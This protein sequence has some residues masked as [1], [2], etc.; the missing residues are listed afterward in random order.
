[1]RHRLGFWWPY[2]V[3]IAVPAG[4]F[5]LPDLFG[6]HLLMTGDDVQQNYPLRELVGYALRH[7]QLPLWNPYLWSGTPLLG[8]F[9]AGA[10]H[11]L[12]LLFG[13]MPARAAWITTEVV[14]YA[15]V[16][17]GAYSF[18]RAL[19]LS[20]VPSFIGAAAFS[21]SGVMLNQIVHIDMV[22]GLATLPW[23]LLAV[24]RLIDEGRWR[25]SVL[26]GVGLGS[27]ILAGAPE[28]MLDEAILVGLY[29]VLSAGIDRE[30]WRRVISRGGTG[31]VFG[32]ALGAIQWLPGLTV[33]SA[34]QR[35]GLGSG[36]TAL[37]SFPPVDGFLGLVP[38]LFGGYGY[39]GESSFFSATLN[40]PE[41]TFYVGVLAVVAAFVMWS[42]RWPS[43]ME[44]RERRTW[45]L[46]ALVGVLLALA[47]Y[48]PLEHLYNALPLYGGQRLRGRNIVDV[49]LALCVLLAGYLDR[50]AGIVEEVRVRRLGRYT[51]AVPLGIAGGLAIWAFASP[52][53]LISALAGANANS[54]E[55]H[56]VRV[57]TLTACGFCATA[58]VLVWLRPYFKRILWLGLA[59]LLMTADLGFMALTNEIRVSVDNQIISGQ[60][61]GDKVVASAVTSAGRFALYDPEQYEFFQMFQTDLPDLNLIN[62]VP[63]LGGY[64]SIVDKTYNQV[65]GAHAIG[66]LLLPGVGDLNLQTLVT[67]PEYFLDPLAAAPGADG[68]VRPATSDSA[69]P[70]LP[71]GLSI[72][73]YVNEAVAKAPPRLALRSPGDEGWFFGTA[74]QPAAAGVVFLQ[75][76]GAAT[77]R[78][79]EITPTGATK[80]GTPISVPKGARALRA[81]LAPLPSVGISLQVLSG[82]IGSHFGYLEA[83]GRAYLLDG[84]L[85]NA[86][87]PPAWRLDGTTGPFAVFRSSDKPVALRA[88]DPKSGKAASLQFTQVSDSFNDSVFRVHNASPITLVRREAWAN[89]W[90]ATISGP[91]ASQTV[92]VARFGLVQAIALAPGTHTVTFSYRP[93]H[94]VLAVV[95]SG[96]GVLVLLA[97]ALWSACSWVLARCRRPEPTGVASP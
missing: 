47:S 1:L 45:Y 19:K 92:D 95:L 32:V 27:V 16:A 70:L 78:F 15:V 56:T 7:G 37:G 81:P 40:F 11:P 55:I 60:T 72:A 64:G 74:A 33:I 34:S 13:I 14:I 65:T 52:A 38:Y 69:D 85:A 42:T 39:A 86:V 49:D 77:V 10:F 89:G 51:A 31:I 93:P 58:L 5:I 12:T 76:T 96:G 84:S 36:F 88:I 66:E 73:S 75:P 3:L 79:G 87:T 26:L 63:S 28:A 20:V 44:H 90:R 35:S 23:M 46:I 53:T 94:F 83:S 80:W 18:L 2:L 21:F 68:T 4:V 43:A 54:R 48:T 59:G 22:E 97:L 50:P 62:R 41:V 25:W 6:G 24:R 17:T 57:A 30:R 29:A 67:V 9:N 82:T 71:G 61:P 91:S 8:G